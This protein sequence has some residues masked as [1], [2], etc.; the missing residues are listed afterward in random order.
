MS[1]VVCETTGRG[2]ML[3]SAVLSEKGRREINEDS[4]GFMT[5]G[6][7]GFFVLADGLGGHGQ[8]E[9]ASRLVTEQAKDHYCENPNDLDG[10]FIKSQNRLIDEQIRTNASEQLK[11]TMV[12]LYVDEEKARW[13]HIGDSRLYYFVAGKL[14]K[15][16]LDHSVP[17]MLVT[18]GE[19]K[20]KEIRGHEDRNRLTRVLGMEWDVP[21][22]ELSE[23][24]VLSGKDVFLLCSDGFWE[25]ITE[26]DMEKTLNKSD[27]PAKWISMM[28][29]KILKNG[30]GKNM[31]NY[32]AIAVFAE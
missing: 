15:R 20:E 31:D 2:A 5:D 12:C 23:E 16:T 4:I 27:S 21:K 30:S 11:T 32:S 26:R 25:W 29:S 1:C 7:A 22:Y 9:V 3:I 13:G 19:I 24:I 28:E 17:Q 6:D 8:G 14:S 10:C 18:I